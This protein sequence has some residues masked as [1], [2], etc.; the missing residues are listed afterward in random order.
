M[1]WLVTCFEPFAQ[2]TSNS[3]EIIWRKLREKNWGGQVLFFGPLPV[4]F[5]DSWRVLQ[6]ELERLDVD[7]VLALG[8]AEGRARIS[9]ECVALNWIDA[10]I[11]DNSGFKPEM[12]PID[13]NFPLALWSNLNWTELGEGER[14]QRSY[15]A[16]TYVCNYLLMQILI[17]AEAR[18][19][20]GG[21]I[22]IP[23]LESQ[24]DEQFKD[25]PKIADVEAE[26][27]LRLILD[28]LREMR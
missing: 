6:V 8:Q 25:V 18:E 20:K 10:R 19:K 13:S 17:W 11:A 5:R 15:S 2:G 21:F 4:T 27:S 28:R 23:V 12:A 1:K 22:H 9:L 26:E 14:W 24:T 3:S 16:G 7:G